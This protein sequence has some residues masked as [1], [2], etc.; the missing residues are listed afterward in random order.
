MIEL[1]ELDER[2]REW[3]SYFKDRHRFNRCKSIEGRFNPFAPGSW[4]SGWGDPG[5]PQ[6]IL[7]EVKL[8][9]VLQ[10]H[11]CVQS[12]QKPYKWAITY[13]Y[14]YPSLERWMTLKLM[15]KYTGR[16]FSWKV[17]LE[18]V[19]LARMRVWACILNGHTVREC[20]DSKELLVP[21]PIS[22]PTT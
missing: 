20:I 22:V 7:P 11:A 13:A 19:D 17:Y 8:P 18:T 10:T 9:R 6:T 1:P 12:L 5:A 21:N 15:K 14:C 2:L 3:S 16:R 4:D